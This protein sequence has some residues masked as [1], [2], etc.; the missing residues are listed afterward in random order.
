MYAFYKKL[1]KYASTILQKPT[2]ILIR[3]FLREFFMT[4]GIFITYEGK[5]FKRYENYEKVVCMIH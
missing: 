1:A 5:V 3:K 2:V 4:G